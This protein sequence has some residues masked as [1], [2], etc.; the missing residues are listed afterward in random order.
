MKLIVKYKEKQPSFYNF[1]NKSK[2]NNKISHAYL[3][4]TNKVSYGFDLAK[5]LAKFFLCKENNNHKDET[6]CQICN[7]INNDNYPD[8]KVIDSEKTIKKE[9]MIELQKSFSVKPLYGKYLIYIIKDV[10]KLNK[11]SAN[12]I[13]KFLEEPSEGIIAILLTDNMYQVM[14]TIISRCKIISLIPEEIKAI[15][16]VN[17]YFKEETK[18]ANEALNKIVSFYKLLEETR[19]I[20]LTSPII[21]ELKDNLKLLFEVGCYLYFDI[22]NQYLKREK[23]NIEGFKEEKKVIM[24]NNTLTEILAKI[25]LIDEFIDKSSYNVNKE[26]L[27]DNFIISFCKVRADVWLK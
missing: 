15:D 5:S 23:E 16:L 10:S 26:L 27:I 21:Y 18:L 22:F 2:E 12:T 25:D 17:A 8:F 20:G 4:E 3:I 19:E 6:T 24:D 9:Q 13:L 11:S 14:D 7:G 1:I